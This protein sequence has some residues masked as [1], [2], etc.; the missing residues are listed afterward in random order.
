MGDLQ[1]FVKSLI[2]M[3]FILAV[4]TL[5]YVVIEGWP[6][7][8]AFY[9]T[10]ITV[11]T[12]GFG[13][14]NPLSDK[15]RI[16][17]IFIIT[18]GMGILGY[19]MYSGTRMIIEGELNEFLTRRRHMKAVQRVSDHY[20]IC[21]FGR[22]GSFICQELH[23][24]GIPFVVVEKDSA[25]MARVLE[26]GYLLASGDGTEEEVL[27]GAGIERA[28]GL[29]SVLPSDSSN[30][31]AVLTARE[32]NPKLQIIARAAE[33][34]AMKKLRRAGADRVVSP[35][36]I[37]GMQMVLG[38]IKPTVVGFLEVVMDHRQ[39]DIELEEIE[40]GPCSE[41][42]GKRLMDTGIRKQLDLI[43]IAI[44]KG[45]GLMQFNPGPDTIVEAGDTLLAMG[46]SEML[47][48]L[49]D[50]TRCERP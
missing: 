46:T 40:V 11:S 2:G 27:R 17:T 21:G 9:M 29:V 47:A 35:Y 8:D 39:L 48:L 13:E 49:R 18:T 44:K 16:F 3:A 22:M 34:T 26:L 42:C 32:L 5:G 36:H 1:P 14:I 25:T 24:R 45:T 50:H 41:Y 10:M 33:D 38:I 31:Y 7:L 4:G 15:G 30:V 19:V 37:G 6:I 43:I 12:I 28:R 20:I 23:G